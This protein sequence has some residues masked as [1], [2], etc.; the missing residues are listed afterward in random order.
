[1]DA[2]RGSVFSWD[3]DK[4][5]VQLRVTPSELKF[6]DT[7]AGKVYR[8]PITLHNLG[9]W[10][11]KIRFQ[12]PSKPQF[13]LVLNNL[14]KELASGLQM[15]AV[16]EYHPYANEDI[17]DK[18]L[19]SAGNKTIEVPLIG[20]IP[21]CQLEIESE[22]NF[23]KLVANGKVYCKE[24][25]VIN[26][27]KSPG[28]FT[29]E[30]QGRL[31][32]LVYP[33]TGTVEAKSSMIVKVDFCADKAC[34]VNEVVRVS[35][36]GHPDAFLSIKANV[37]EQIIELLNANGEKKLDCV[38]FG[39]TFFGTSKIEYAVLYN[40]SPETLNWVAIMQDN[41]VGEELGTNIQQRTDVALN[42]LTYI[43]KMEKV[44]ITSFISCIPNEGNLLP[45]QKTKITFCFSPKLIYD[46]K[47]DVDP[48][49]RQDYALFLRFESVG[50]KDELM[51]DDDNTLRKNDRF[52]KVELALTGSGIPVLLQFN[53]AKVF[54][55][56]PCIM[57][58]HSE[59]LCLMQNRSDSLPIMYH[60]QKTAHFKIDPKKGK[61]DEGCIQNVVCSFIPHQIG[62]FKSK[63]VVEIIGLVADESFQS[64]SMKPFHHIYLDFHGVCRS[65]KKKV[66]MKVNPGISPA[67]TNPVGEFVVEDFAKGKDYAPVAMLQSAGTTHIHSHQA[68]K[69]VEEDA[70][71][72]LPNDRAASIRSGERDE[73]FRT[74]FTEMARYHYI[75]PDFAYTKSEE[76]GRKGHRSHYDNYIKYSRNTR[77]QKQAKRQHKYPC[78]DA[79]VDLQSTSGFKPPDIT[80]ADVEEEIPSTKH[81]SKKDKLLSTKNMEAKEAE[82]LK[83]KVLSGFKLEP[84]TPQEIQDCCLNLTPK[85]IHQVNIGPSVL[86]FGDVCLNSTNIRPLHVINTLPTHVLVKLDINSKELQ[87]TEQL[88]YVIPPTTSTYVSIIFKSSIIGK[89]WK[90]FTFTVNNIPGGHILVMA[91]IQPVKLEL[92]SNE[93]VLTP[94]NFS[95]KACFKGIIRIYNRK[96]YFAQFKWLPANK[97]KKMAFT[98]SPSTVQDSV[99]PL[100]LL[101]FLGVLVV[102]CMLG[103][104]VRE[105]R[106]VVSPPRQPVGKKDSKGGQLSESFGAARREVPLNESWAMSNSGK[107]RLI[108]IGGITIL[109]ISCTPTVAE[110]FE[111]KAKVAIHHSDVI[112]LRI[113]GTVEIADVEIDPGEFNF[114]GTYVGTTQIIPFQIINKGVTR[115]RVEL[116]LKKRINFSLDFKDKSVE[117]AD[118]KFPKKYSM[119]IEE[120]TSLECGL[121]FSPEE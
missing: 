110:T 88:S 23:G 83:K 105:R 36:Q 109:N 54:K 86:N 91:A 107:N 33:N 29:A 34:V 8:L 108:P 113:G 28:V 118:P 7:A 119:E 11:Q 38:R 2:E 85:Q 81:Q 9:R 25:H 64:L 59:I 93:L 111:T 57:G 80:G 18:L 48:S 41:S 84:L 106:L 116:D 72:A 19:I 46:C 117:Y 16:V 78:D 96:N 97:D 114:S 90:S 103:R 100:P 71:V 14:D 89:F 37:V 101:G 47:K 75:D 95:A 121:A 60:F 6:L 13:K 99:S 61:L 21:S 70:Q 49:H 87:K 5:Q 27:G 15:T 45:Y 94:Y 120:N 82:S 66:Q 76:L 30:Y 4:K 68:N 112:D 74:I 26:S 50:S 58:E 31:P 44:D 104:S 24:I 62:S 43:S 39:S 22:V 12:E 55:F 52:Q 98:I 32:I 3:T 56:P 51:E 77:L 35:L 63:Q 20:R 73:R 53:P 115:A 67:V 69:K 17:F 102:L 65:Q 1:M 40:N 92:S 10:N 42:N 79:D